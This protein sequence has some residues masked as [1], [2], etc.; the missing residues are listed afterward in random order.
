MELKLS[1]TTLLSN[2]YTLL[3]LPYVIETA[4]CRCLL[5][6]LVLL[7]VLYGIETQTLRLLKMMTSQLLIVPDL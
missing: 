4:R 7:I 5:F 1:I 6:A 2:L 3:I